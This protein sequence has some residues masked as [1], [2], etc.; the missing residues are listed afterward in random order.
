MRVTLA[1][2]PVKPRT[3]P[4]NWRRGCPL[5][6]FLPILILFC[7][8]FSAVCAWLCR[9]ALKGAAAEADRATIASNRAKAAGDAAHQSALTAGSHKAA[10]QKA[11]EA[12]KAEPVAYAITNNFPAA[13]SEPLF[14]FPVLERDCE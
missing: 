5:R 14:H 9:V 3:P 12:A 1:R 10:A 4:R 13:D 7:I 6:T 2:Q 11:V 8:V